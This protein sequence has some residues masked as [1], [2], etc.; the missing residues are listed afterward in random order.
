MMNS[1]FDIVKWVPGSKPIGLDEPEAPAQL[2]KTIAFI[3]EQFAAIEKS[4]V[5]A[6]KILVGGFSQ[7]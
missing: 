3:H 7:G 1:W 4:G 5:P 2:D 6:D